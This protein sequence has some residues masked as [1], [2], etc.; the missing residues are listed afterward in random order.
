[1][2][3]EQGSSQQDTTSSG[4]GIALRVALLVAVVGAAGVGWLALQA[5]SDP[6][7]DGERANLEPTLIALSTQLAY[8]R[9]QADPTAVPTEE[10]PTASATAPAE[11][12]LV[13]YAEG[14]PGR[15]YLV[16]QTLSG[17]EPVRLTQGPGDRDPAI[18]P[19]GSQVAFR[20]QRD[21]PW[22][23]Y[24]LELA[25]GEVRRLTQTDA[26]EGHPTWSPD[27]RW[28]AYEAYSDGDLDIWILPL[29]GGAAIQLTNHPGLDSEPHWDPAG[30]RRVAFISTRDGSRDVFLA[31]LDRSGDRYRNLTR[32]PDFEEGSPAFSPDGSSLAYSTS[33]RGLDLLW[34]V[35]PG[36]PQAP[37][38][39]RGPG[40]RPVWSPDGEHLLATLRSPHEQHLVVYPL[41]GGAALSVPVRVRG[42]PLT[43]D[44][45][46]RSGR[47]ATASRQQAETEADDF[48]STTVPQEQVGRTSLVDLGDVDAPNPS[49]VAAAEEPFSALRSRTAQLVGWDFLGSLDYA[50]VGLNDPLPPGFAFNDWLYTGRAFAFPQRAYRADWVE[51]V[52]EDFGGQ[53]YWRVYIRAATQDGSQGEPLR[54]RPWDFDARYRGD[55]RDYDRGGRRMESIPSGYYVDFTALAE[56]YGFERQAALNNWHTFLPGARF[57]EYAYTQGLTWQQAM[58]QLYP[59]E[60]IATPT[61]FSSP[62]ATPTNTPWPTATPWWWRWRTPTPSPEPSQPPSPSPT[63]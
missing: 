41:A 15:S 9:A 43:A 49:F 17:G 53:T 48:R 26:Y 4:R 7:A 22:E 27:G 6:A 59:L 18:S 39:Q 50:F 28:L 46:A 60:A 38:V 57:N 11:T 3:S 23:L 34:T 42:L 2:T 56:A 12:G 21:G 20:S 5:Y 63:P 31:D 44:W 8:E 40:A 52:R 51:V 45:G 14:Q 58:L 62:T 19:D 13:V 16:G 32:S 47:L 54:R 29:D 37:P 35:N 61:P 36:E 25:T 55:P 30:G 24:L 33:E 1:M 10:P